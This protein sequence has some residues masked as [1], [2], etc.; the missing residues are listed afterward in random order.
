[1]TTGNKNSHLRL[2]GERLKPKQSTQTFIFELNFGYTLV[3]MVL[4]E[5]FVYLNTKW[6]ILAAGALNCANAY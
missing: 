1:M 5:Q 2:R 4:E 3:F 6:I